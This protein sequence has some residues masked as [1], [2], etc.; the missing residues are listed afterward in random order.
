MALNQGSW[1][2][3]KPY[4]DGGQRNAGGELQF[5]ECRYCMSLFV[6]V[7]KPPRW[8]TT[9]TKRW[10]TNAQLVHRKC[11]SAE[12]SGS[13]SSVPPPATRVLLAMG[14]CLGTN[15]SISLHQTGDLNF[16]LMRAHQQCT[17]LN[18]P[19]FEFQTSDKRDERAGRYLMNTHWTPA[20]HTARFKYFPSLAWMNRNN[21][22]GVGGQSKREP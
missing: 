18:V 13:A 5:F 7:I 3:E 15:H 6:S 21:Y 11:E 10:A 1:L 19:G 16:A 22:A 2:G 14:S 8:T 12:K 20:N 17:S 4:D 9:K